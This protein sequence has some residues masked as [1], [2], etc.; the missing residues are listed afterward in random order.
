MATGCAI[1]ASDT[2]PVREVIESGETGQLFPFFD[3]T[4][5]LDRIDALLA[6]PGERQR[7]GAAARAQVVSAY[8]LH[9]ICLPRQIE[10]VD[11]LRR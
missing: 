2:A 10:W 1:V 11:R 8:D 3:R 6:S 9:T 7:L 4:A 5:M